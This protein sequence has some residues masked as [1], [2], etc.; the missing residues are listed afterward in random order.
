[1][2]TNDGGLDLN[3]FNSVRGPVI[4]KCTAAQQN[5]PQALCTTG[6]ILAFEPTSNQTYKGLL[7]KADKRL[8]RGLQVLGSYA[9]SSNTG[10][11]GSGGTSTVGLNL[12]NW[13]K[14]PGPL[15]TDYTHIANLAGVVQ[16]P[17]RFELG[18]NFFLLERAAVQRH[19]WRNRFQ[20]RRDHRR[21]AAWDYGECVQPGLGRSDVV[22]LVD[23][24][25]QTY[26]GYER[27]SRPPIPRLTLP[28]SYALGD[29]FHSLDLQLSQTFLF[30]DPW[31]LSLIG[32]VFNLSTR[33]T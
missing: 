19:R 24:F 22:R 25:D 8:S 21:S 16:L 27:S 17:K 12:D 5:D 18:L 1:L 32:E 4:P 29:N 3:H 31:R 23:A 13:H 33:R 14:D 20:R 26:A 10:T 11:A 2:G 6:P 9:W 28:A 30:R 15:P 7:L